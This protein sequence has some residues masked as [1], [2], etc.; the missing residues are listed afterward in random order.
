MTQK[1]PR[2]GVLALM[3]EDYLPLF[4]GIDRAQTAYVNEVLDGLRDAAE[5]VFPHAAMN[6]AQIESLVAQYNHEKLDGILI[7]LLTYSQGAYLVRAL[8]EHHLPLALALIQPEQTVR[9]DFIEWDYT[10]YQGPYSSEWYWAKI[11]HTIRQDP[12]VRAVAYTWVEHCDWM[13]NLLAGRTRPELAYRCACAAGHKAYWHS[14]W[15][16]LPAKERLAQLD[17]YLAQV[18]DTFIQ[19]PEPCTAVV[20]TITQEWAQ[21]LHLPA[22]TLI[23]GGSFDAHAGAVGAGVCAGTMVV[24]IGTSAVNMMVERADALRGT[25]F[26]ELAGQAENSILPGYVGIETSQS[27]F[28]DTYAWLKRLLLW[29]LESLLAGSSLPQEQQNALTQQA[30]Q[31]LL[32]LLEQAAKALPPQPELVA[33]DWFNGRRYPYNNDQA[34]S[35]VCGLDL[36]VS[37]PALYRAL[38]E[39][40]AYGQRRI[41]TGLTEH[42]IRIDRIVAVGGIAQKSPFVMQ[43]LSDVLQRPITVSPVSQ[44]C[45]LG[46]AIYASVGAGLYASVEQAQAAIC[47]PCRTIY[48]PDPAAAAYHA[49]KYQRYCELCRKIDASSFPG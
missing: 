48:Q 26:A 12:V 9:P 17:P 6:R 47:R 5:F 18:H 44:T 2:L 3:L 33:L 38:V 27:A 37:A 20:G 32:P 16:G 28:G 13:A 19:P 4:P 46:A 25:G 30:G 34:S 14:A 39:A 45:A 8:E 10:V 24:N 22:Q 35:A 40:T 7:L 42:G 41:V 23:C 1:K 15:G 11:L 29:P 31:Q 43:T 21:R 49:Q 36:G